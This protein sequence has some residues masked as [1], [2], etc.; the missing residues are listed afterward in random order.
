M[1][2][3]VAK[4]VIGFAI[5]ACLATYALSIAAIVVSLEEADDAC[6]Q[7]YSGISFGY[8][9]W[10]YVYG[11][12][13]IALTTVFILVVTTGAFS[14]S[15]SSPVA[16]SILC[17]GVS[18]VVLGGL[19]EFAWFI[20]GAVLFFKEVA[21]D[22]PSGHLLYDFGLALFII[23]CVGYACS[24]GPGKVSVQASV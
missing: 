20:V 15:L 2:A 24:V 9:T 5:I 14:E 10:L 18:V 1:N 17:P 12:T 8:P 3:S 16:I 19:F 22:C 21:P 23:Q 6:L 11:V 7:H 4:Y 13:S